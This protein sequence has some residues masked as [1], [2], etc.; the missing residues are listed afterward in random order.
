MDFVNYLQNQLKLTLSEK[1]LQCLLHVLARE[2][3]QGVI[4]YDEFKQVVKDYQKKEKVMRKSMELGIK[5][6][7]IS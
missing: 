4:L 1:E 6:D 7:S 5:Y 3:L 2:D